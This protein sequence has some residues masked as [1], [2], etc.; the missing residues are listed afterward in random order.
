MHQGQGFGCCSGSWTIIYNDEIGERK[1]HAREF[2]QENEG[3][4]R[5]RISLMPRIAKAER[6]TT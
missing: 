2:E 4:E 6:K 5:K 3:Y 1:K